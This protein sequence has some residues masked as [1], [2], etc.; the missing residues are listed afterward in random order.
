[1]RFKESLSLALSFRS[2]TLSDVS[3]D[4]EIATTVQD[5]Y[6]L[7]AGEIIR[8]NQRAARRRERGRQEGKKE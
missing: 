4:F 5:I 1:M 8:V 7:A 3:A 6:L 2:L